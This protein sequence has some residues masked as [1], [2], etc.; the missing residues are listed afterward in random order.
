MKVAPNDGYRER[1]S[2][3]S[4][5]CER[6][7]RA[8]D[9]EPDRNLLL[10]RS[11]KNALAGKGRPEAALPGHVSLIAQLQEKIELFREQRIV[12]LHGEAEQRIGFPERTAPDHDLR[13]TFGDEIHSGEFLEHANRI[14]GA[15]DADSTGKANA[16]GAGSHRRE[17]HR[18]C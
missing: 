8:A 2:Q 3:G 6:L 15:K 10:M 12:V 11:W 16:L 7:R 1:K 9:A 5:A 13:P 4:G 18:W 14:G 17:D